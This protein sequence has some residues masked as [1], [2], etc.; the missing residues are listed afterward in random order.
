MSKDDEDIHAC[1]ASL[2]KGVGCKLGP[3]LLIQYPSETDMIIA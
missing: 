3:P 1:N 2:L